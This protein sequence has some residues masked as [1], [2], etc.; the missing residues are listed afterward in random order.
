MSAAKGN[1][2]DGERRLAAEVDARAAELCGG[3]LG[4]Y[5]RFVARLCAGETVMVRRFKDAVVMMGR[6]YGD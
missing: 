3:D 1:T 2:A 5:L 6:T 4:L